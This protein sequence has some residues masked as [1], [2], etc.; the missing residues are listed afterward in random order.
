MTSEVVIVS[1]LHLGGLVGVS[2]LVMENVY[3]E[4]LT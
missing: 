3:N 4:N 2:D 1:L